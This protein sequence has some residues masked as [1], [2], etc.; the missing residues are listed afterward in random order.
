MAWLQGLHPPFLERGGGSGAPLVGWK[1]SR[2]SIPVPVCLA[3]S[4]C[5]GTGG[6]SHLADVVAVFGG[7]GEQGRSVGGT[8]GA[9]H[10]GASLWGR[11]GPLPGPGKAQALEPPKCRQR[12]GDPKVYLW[13]DPAGGLRKAVGGVASSARFLVVLPLE[14][15]SVS[16]ALSLLEKAARVTSFD[17]VGLSPRGGGPS[18]GPPG[19]ADGVAQERL[20]CLA[21]PGF[22]GCLHG[23]L[24]A[25][26]GRV[27][28]PRP[29]GGY[30]GPTKELRQALHGRTDPAEG[31]AG[32]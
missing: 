18:P 17:Q 16:R 6:F 27:T 29:R 26:R 9:S 21:S 20:L 14:A 23:R 10:A 7:E 24:S 19:A 8:V 31:K 1:A 30:G 13:E 11:G 12:L 4:S 25:P 28:D 32:R 15:S 5:W 3:I 22:S 2:P